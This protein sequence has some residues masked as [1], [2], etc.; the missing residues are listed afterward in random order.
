MGAVPGDR[1]RELGDRR[2]DAGVRSVQGKGGGLQEARQG[3]LM[4]QR[5][6]FGITF[7]PTDPPNAFNELTSY[8]DGAGFDYLWLAD[9]SLYGRYVY[10]Y[11][12]L[13]AL[14]TRHVKIGPNCTHPL[15]RN[16]AVSFNAMATIDE[17]SMGRAIMNVGAGGGT[18]KE[19]GH[20]AAKMKA[21][22]EMI[23]QGRALM[24]GEPVDY[25]SETLVLKNA[26][27]RFLARNDMPI[28]MTASGPKMLEMAGELCDGVIY[29]AGTDPRCIEAAQTDIAR[30]AAAAGRSLANIDRACCVFGNLGE[31]RDKARAHCRSIAAWMVTTQPRYAELAGIPAGPIEAV[32]D[33][34][35]GSAHGPEARK[36]AALVTDQMIDAFT[37]AGDPSDFIRGIE[38]IAEYGVR[39]VEFFPEGGNN[40]EMTQLFAKRVIPHFR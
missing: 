16:P 2:R 1:G 36:A 5:I 38:R 15:T 31:D 10:S 20:A 12:T 6:S 11:L 8:V 17:L 33:A 28:Y 24:T 29:M 3:R 22:R 39:H 9:A 26:R 7:L 37:L 13:S 34:F 30:G 4:G 14:N 25:S 32:R 19:L 40:L 27:L 23:E 21:I 18:V 35:S